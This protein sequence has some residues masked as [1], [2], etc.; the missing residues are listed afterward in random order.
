M[1]FSIIRFL[2]LRNPSLSCYK[3]KTR[4]ILALFVLGKNRLFSPL[5]ETY[6]G[7]LKI[8]FFPSSLYFEDVLVQKLSHAMSIY[9]FYQSD[10][11]KYTVKNT[12]KALLE[13][14]RDE[15]LSPKLY[16]ESQN[17]SGWR[18]IRTSFVQFST[19]SRS[20]L[21]GQTTLLR[22]LFSLVL[23]LS[24]NRETK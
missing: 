20:K 15:K 21:W 7:R 11:S 9:F 10:I 14:N 16:I 12:T 24:K 4:L 5:S 17:Y 19:Q 2:I 13:L 3:V 6:H 22:A 8:Y 18:D 1:I 23:N